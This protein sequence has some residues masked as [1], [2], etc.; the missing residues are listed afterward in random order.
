MWVTIFGIYYEIIILSEYV[1]EKIKNESEIIQVNNISYRKCI[2]IKK[3]KDRRN[4]VETITTILGNVEDI[5]R[6]W[7]SKMQT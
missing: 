1:I 5:E 3:D 4:Y 2:W 7:T 6:S